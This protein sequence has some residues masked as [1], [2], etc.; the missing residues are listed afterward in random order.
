VECLGPFRLLRRYRGLDLERART[1]GLR[2]SR[3]RGGGLLGRGGAA[4]SNDH[5]KSRFKRTGPAHAVREDVVL[6]GRILESDEDKPE[7]LLCKR[8]EVTLVWPQTILRIGLYLLRYSLDELAARLE[9]TRSG[10]WSGSRKGT[11]AQSRRRGRRVGQRSCP[12][13][14]H[15]GGGGRGSPRCPSHVSLGLGL[16]RETLT[17]DRLF[18]FF[19]FLDQWDLF[20]NRP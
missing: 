13:R 3:S 19:F 16:A 12:A 8:S 10:G 2:R 1:R 15:G 6:E 18:F 11:R 9:G 14:R 5:G 4:L 20:Q 17:E 7:D